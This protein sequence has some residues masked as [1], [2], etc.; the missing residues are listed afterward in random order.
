MLTR[1]PNAPGTP[2]RVSVRTQSDLSRLAIIVSAGTRSRR[3]ESGRR[4]RDARS[5]GRSAD[6][7]NAVPQSGT[8]DDL[9]ENHQVVLILRLVLDRRAELR[10]GEVL[11]AESGRQGRFESIAGLATMVQ[12]CLERQRVASSW[13]DTD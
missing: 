9:S 6:K 2:A 5:L 12:Q 4:R 3:V 7:G 13:A 10:Y 1:L 8:T 11:D